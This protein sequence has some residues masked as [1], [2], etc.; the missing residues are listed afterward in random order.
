VQKQFFSAFS[1]QDRIEIL[2]ARVNFRAGFVYMIK[3]KWYST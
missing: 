2:Q 3:I 1:T